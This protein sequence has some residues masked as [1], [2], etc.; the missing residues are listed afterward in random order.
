MQE[1]QPP[2]PGARMEYCGS[3]I[4]VYWEPQYCIH[5]ANCVRGLPQVFDRKRRPWIQIG[6]ETTAEE[7]ARVIVTCPTGALHFQRLD[8]GAQES[9]PDETVVR[10]EPNGPLFITG[11]IKIVDAQGTVVREDT[12]VAL[13]RCGQSSNKP[14]CD[15]T[16]LS[17]DF[18]AG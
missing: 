9:P 8:G 17:V 11:K 6:P 2:G 18:Q 12:R 5:V 14:F 4:I 3:D 16:H 10:P 15:G 1:N 13:C 7:L